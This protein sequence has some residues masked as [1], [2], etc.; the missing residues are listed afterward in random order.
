MDPGRWGPVLTTEADTAERDKR[1][2]FPAGVRLLISGELIMAMG[3]GLTQPYAVVLLH[4][5]RGFS[6]A[7]STGIWAL[8]P[9]ITI[10]GNTVA[11]PLIDRR[12]GR[13]VMVTGLAVVAAGLLVLAYGPGVASAVAG[14]MIGGLG[15]SFLVPAMGTRLAILSPESI[16]SRV[17]TAQYVIFNLGMAIGAGLGAVAFA[18][19]PPDTATGKS[20]LPLLWVVGAATCVVAIVLSMFAGRQMPPESSDTVVRRGG[21]R[22]ALRD[23][24]LLRVLG[25]YALLS[26][27]GLGIY[28][29]APSVLALAADDPAALGWAGVANSAAVVAGAPIALRLAN[30]ISARAALHYTAV[31]WAVGWAI[32]IP[33]VFGVGLNTRAAL[34][35]A[36]VLIGF[37]ELLI[38]GAIPT[39]VNAVAPDELRG[40]YNAL[41]NLAQTLGLAAGPL[42]T[43]A[44]VAAR[45]TDYLLYSTIALAGLASLLVLRDPLRGGPEPAAETE[46]LV[47]DR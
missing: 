12:G 41:A 31:L 2:P 25:A 40:R 9:V 39:L 47:K 24:T 18:R 20:V 19:T 26:T 14:V 16:R 30:R 11:G 8:G 21:Y 3:V 13:L 17:Y 29:A 38:A 36:S 32:C 7:L 42:L 23:R 6:L 45:S 5:V 1:I 28:N 35:V 10:F 44:S 15:F 37:G 4:E 27:V 34:T 33:T 43:S 46:G 22:R